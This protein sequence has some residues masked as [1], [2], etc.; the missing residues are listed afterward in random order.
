MHPTHTR[1]TYLALSIPALLVA[2]GASQPALAHKVVVFATV[3]ADTIRGEAYFRGGDPVRAAKVSVVGP[4]QNPLGETTTDDEGL[5]TFTARSRVSHTLIVDAGEGHGG[6]YTVPA[7]E[8]PKNLPSAPPGPNEAPAGEPAPPDAATTPEREPEAVPA[9]VDPKTLEARIDAVAT[10]IA[11]LRK[12]LDQYKNEV[13]L[14]DLLGGVGY[15][16]GIMGLVFYFLGVRRKE[17]RPPIR[18]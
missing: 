15:I 5:F 18:D 16:L 17:S 6:Q 4:D 11:A 3:D 13:R 10:Q 8:L 14:Q 1:P 2:L 12:D 9:P 7:D